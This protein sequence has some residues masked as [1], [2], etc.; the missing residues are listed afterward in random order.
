[1]HQCL[2][3]AYEDAEELVEAAEWFSSNSRFHPSKGPTGMRVQ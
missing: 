3:K 2:L 1:M